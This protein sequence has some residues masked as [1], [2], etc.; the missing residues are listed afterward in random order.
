MYISFIIV[1]GS[2]SAYVS[3]CPNKFNPQLQQ[4]LHFK[5]QILSEATSGPSKF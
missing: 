2:S 1:I 4:D 5:S 3:H